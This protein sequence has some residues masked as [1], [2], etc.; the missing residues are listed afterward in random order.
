MNWNRYYRPRTV[1][2][3]HLT[4]VKQTLLEL[5]AQG[6]MPQVML[7]AGPKGT[8]KTSTARIIAAV[9]NEPLNQAAVE[10]IFFQKKAET[11]KT[12]AKPLALQEPQTESELIDKIIAGTSFLVQE[13]DAASNRGI[14]DVRSLKERINLPPQQGLMSVYILD[15]AHMLTTE[16]FNALLKLLEEPPPHVAFILATTEL[17]KIPAT[18]VSRCTTLN[19]TKATPEEL[20]Q[21]M[22]SVLKAEA[23]EFEPE[24]LGLIATAADGSFR[25]A[26]KNLELVAA[27]QK[28]IDVARTE[29][30]LTS[31]LTEE[32]T[33]LAELIVSKDAR[34]V[35]QLFA[36][37][38][39]NNRDPE[40]FFKQL[41]AYLHTSLLQSLGVVPGTTTVP[42]AVAQ[43]LLSELQTLS[44]ST[45]SGIPFLPLEL[46]SLDLI[47]RAQAKGSKTAPQSGSSSSATIKVAPKIIPLENDELKI[48]HQPAE[49]IETSRPSLIPIAPPE[50]LVSDNLEPLAEGDSAKL[51]EQ[52]EAFIELV[53]LKN[54]SVA[55]LLRSAKPLSSEKGKA[56]VAV[57]YKFHQEQLQQP[58]FRQ[59][60]DDCLEPMLGGKVKLEFV[61][62]EPPTEKAADTVALA[63]ELLV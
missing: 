15:E 13:M 50:I 21:A 60:I 41:C 62:A 57:F 1:Y 26:I 10:Q 56:V 40:F 19:F 58:K 18:I 22:S 20:I 7:F 42:Q 33:Q 30:L 38:R 45:S 59:M 36:S 52:W 3:L 37:L 48:A 5:M 43:F 12:K 24:A 54:S 9:L 17:H 44:L 34:G 49:T 27:G 29:T 46:K 63:E 8:G 51:L 23:I 14:D 47:F 6:R 25:D 4:K 61:L 55:A 53:N 11:A 39:Q 35:S 32:V 31:S 16:A 2:G 28:K